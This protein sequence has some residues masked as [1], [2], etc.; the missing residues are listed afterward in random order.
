[1]ECNWFKLWMTTQKKRKTDR[2]K[3]C[4]CVSQCTEQQATT[5]TKNHKQINNK[6]IIRMT[7][8]HWTFF[9]ILFALRAELSRITCCA[10]NC[11]FGLVCGCV[12]NVHY[13]HQQ[14][15]INLW[16]KWLFHLLLRI[17]HATNDVVSCCAVFCYTDVHWLIQLVIHTHTLAQC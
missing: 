5:T 1:M 2:S 17:Y 7:P 12:P 15:I 11:Q 13:Y 8:I 4:L 14:T 16:I 3:E 6:H 9:F 10:L